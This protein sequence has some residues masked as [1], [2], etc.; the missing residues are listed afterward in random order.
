M[1]D[2]P[3]EA[4]S[5]LKELEPPVNIW[6]SIDHQLSLKENASKKARS[7]KLV[8]WSLAA[9]AILVLGFIIFSPKGFHQNRLNY[10]EEWLTV[11]QISDSTEN[12]SLAYRKLAEKCESKPEVCKSGEFIKLKKELDFLDQSR[13][14]IISQSTPYDNNKDM[15]VVLERID[16]ERSDILD[17]LM[18]YADR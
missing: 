15:Q 9:S 11:T 7:L 18:A 2:L 8:Y 6:Q 1:P 12:D 14:I 4:I 5:N 3:A 17:R 13:Q 10:S 16:A